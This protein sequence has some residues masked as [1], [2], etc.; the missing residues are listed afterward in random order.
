MARKRSAEGKFTI[1]GPLEDDHP[2][3]SLGAAMSGALTFA[4]RHRREE[5][6]FTY[7]VRDLVGTA[8]AR[9]TKH[10]NGVISLTPLAT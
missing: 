4:N 1:S 7:Y 2:A 8:Y 6:E 10:E 5:G 9:A 3:P